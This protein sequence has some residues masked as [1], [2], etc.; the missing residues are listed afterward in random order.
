[1]D[2]IIC[3]NHDVRAGWGKSPITRMPSNYD[4]P[5][6]ITAG[7]PQQTYD[8]Y[9]RG[10]DSACVDIML[11]TRLPD[12]KVPAVLL[13]KRKPNVGFGGKW[14]MHG[15]ALF[16]YEDVRDF[17]AA[18]ATKECGIEVAPE[19]LVGV[20]RTCSPDVVGS[21]MQA[22]YAA[23]VPYDVAVEK[24][25][26]DEGHTEVGLFTQ[27]HIEQMSW[28]EHWYPM[29]VAMLVLGGMPE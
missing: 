27:D 17:A 10:C 15:G 8:A 22:C 11:C 23:R 5:P 18:K 14:W 1:M 4:V 9:R 16:A 19:V 24:M 2:A 6:D 28:R 25:R 7:V 21:T 3:E 13:S 12:G 26:K 20:Y 29:R